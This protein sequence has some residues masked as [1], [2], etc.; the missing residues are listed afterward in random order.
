MNP[1]VNTEMIDSSLVL[2]LLCSMPYVSS[3]SKIGT[4]DQSPPNFQTMVL[5]LAPKSSHIFAFQLHPAA[6]GGHGVP[7]PYKGEI[8][9]ARR[10]YQHLL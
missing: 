9:V 8:G 5:G 6:L 10:N 4:S 1:S 2:N 7:C 3:L